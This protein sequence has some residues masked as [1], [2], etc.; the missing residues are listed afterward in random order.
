MAEINLK[1]AAE[2]L[3]MSDQYLRTA[4]KRY[5]LEKLAGYAAPGGIPSIRKVDPVSGI[6]RLWFD[7]EAIEAF[8]NRSKTRASGQSAVDG[9]R[10][11][12]VRISEA[13]PKR[14]ARTPQSPLCVHVPTPFS[15]EPGG[16]STSPTQLLRQRPRRL[17]A[18]PLGAWL[19]VG[20]EQRSSGA[21][22][23]GRPDR[24]IVH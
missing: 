3:G 13:E 18:E 8:A 1:A 17:A 23:P 2:K 21:R 4:A 24:R 5:A 14:G 20:G 19:R 12:R 22:A 11:R 15:S 10:A 16:L 6:E 9:R 7:E